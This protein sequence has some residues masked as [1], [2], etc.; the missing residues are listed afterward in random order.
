MNIVG[1]LIGFVLGALCMFLLL[2]LMAF[3]KGD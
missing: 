1:I 2:C 3:R